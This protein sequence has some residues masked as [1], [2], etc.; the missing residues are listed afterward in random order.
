MS[1]ILNMT[2]CVN[3]AVLL[4]LL[5]IC[6]FDVAKISLPLRKLLLT[7]LL[8]IIETVNIVKILCYD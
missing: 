1:T 7:C 6:I 5:L 2:N 4:Q 3:T 8:N